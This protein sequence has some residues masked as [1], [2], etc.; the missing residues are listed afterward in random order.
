MNKNKNMKNKKLW[1]QAIKDNGYGI[2]G[3]K[4]FAILSFVREMGCVSYTELNKFS[5][6]YTRRCKKNKEYNAYTDI[7]YDKKANRGYIGANLYC[8]GYIGKCLCKYRSQY[9]LNDAGDRKL[10]ELE[11]KFGYK[12][13]T[14]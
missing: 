11:N 1:K 4:L 6:N 14:K 10:A 7:K 9:E 3:H 8:G 13:F 12:L 5:Y 2:R